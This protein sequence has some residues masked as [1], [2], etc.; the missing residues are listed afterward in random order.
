[1]V[2]DLRADFNI[3]SQLRDL[4]IHLCQVYT[5]RYYAYRRIFV[6]RDITFWL[7]LVYP[8]SWLN[9]WNGTNYAIEVYTPCCS[10]SFLYRVENMVFDFY[11][12]L[13]QIYYT[14]TLYISKGTEENKHNVC[15][16][17]CIQLPCNQ[18]LDSMRGTSRFHYKVVS[19]E[20]IQGPSVNV[21][22]EITLKLRTTF[23]VCLLLLSSCIHF[24][25]LKFRR[26]CSKR[27][28]GKFRGN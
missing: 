28:R 19:S 20:E 15:F 25:R 3:G 13:Y 24:L 4:I 14:F 6:F 1:M 7:V 22:L 23:R 8:A 5:T 26:A 17:I 16:L 10:Y 12:D 27:T 9:S 2:V 11:T 18:L 21:L